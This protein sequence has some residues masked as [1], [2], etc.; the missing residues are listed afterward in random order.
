MVPRSFKKNLVTWHAFAF[1]AAD[2]DIAK[3]FQFTKLFKFVTDL[4]MYWLHI[5]KAHV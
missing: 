1:A 3:A 2:N 4:A 5:N